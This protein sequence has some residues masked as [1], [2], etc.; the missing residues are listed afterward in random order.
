MLTPAQQPYPDLQNTFKGQ[1]GKELFCGEGI[2]QFRISGDSRCKMMITFWSQVIILIFLDIISV[3]NISDVI[4][5]QNPL[6]PPSISK[7]CIDIDWMLIM[8]NYYS[9]LRIKS[10]LFTDI[11][12]NFILIHHKDILN[13]TQS[14]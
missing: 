12:L 1:F 11:I 2:L 6:S 4:T 5:F 13:V 8:Y 7:Y 9:E 14:I 3:Y 10:E